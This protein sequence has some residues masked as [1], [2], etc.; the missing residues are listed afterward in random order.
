MGRGGHNKKCF[1]LVVRVQYSSRNEEGVDARGVHDPKQVLWTC[2]SCACYL[3]K[4][5]HAVSGALSRARKQYADELEGLDPLAQESF[6]CMNSGAFH[7]P[8]H[9]MSASTYAVTAHAIMCNL[10]VAFTRHYRK[11][12]TVVWE[13][14]AV[15]GQR[16]YDLVYYGR[17][18]L[19][20]V[21]GEQHA[22]QEALAYDMAKSRAALEEGYHVVRLHFAHMPYWRQV[23]VGA[24]EAAMGGK[25]AR[26]HYT[27]GYPDKAL[28][29]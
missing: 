24:V 12:F 29:L 7:C 20:E 11:S 2:Y 6:L 15:S 26:V 23:I 27:P 5:R 13:V 14:H 1:G 8:A 22:D 17:N 25:P 9:D 28:A 3:F 21:D 19:V 4:S 10:A 16:A 18:V